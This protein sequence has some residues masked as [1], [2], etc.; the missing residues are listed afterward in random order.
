MPDPGTVMD[1]LDSAALQA[2]LEASQ[3]GAALIDTADSSW[4]VS[5][6]NPAFA[7]LTASHAA[8]L[9]SDSARVLLDRVGGE[10][11]VN[12]LRDAISS[13]AV[14]DWSVAT[15]EQPDLL[16][17]YVPLQDV[18][19][20]RRSEGWLFIRYRDG[21]EAVAV[22]R[23]MRRELTASQRRLKELSD[24]PATGLAGSERF[25]ETL[26]RETAIAARQ[27]SAIALVILRMDAY[28]TY[29]ETFGEHATDSCLRMLAR[30]VTRRLRRGSD[31]AARIAEDSIAILMHEHDSAAADAFA[32]RIVADIEALRIHH[33]RSDTARYVTV[34]PSSAATVPESDH[35]AL[36]W[37][38]DLMASIGTG[39]APP[40]L[41]NSA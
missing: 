22:D 24:D 12:Q 38:D 3:Q 39:Q 2:A 29:R 13:A 36:A 16:F 37:L 23:S 26:L 7:A 27:H 31:L 15:A 25:R 11:A 32:R 4:R 9:G 40:P 5:W 34:T 41:L 30:T 35:N 1:Q 28:A 8:A 17:R 20:V 14:T 19:G 18:H 21:D 33:P 6:F 10:S